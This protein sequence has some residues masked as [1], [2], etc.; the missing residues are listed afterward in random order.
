MVSPGQQSDGTRPSE[1]KSG[2]IGFH[3]S[4]SALIKTAA[5]CLLAI[6][7]L[8]VGVLPV[9]AAEGCCAREAGPSVYAP[10]PCCDESTVTPREAV[11]ILPAMSAGLV[12]AAPVAAIVVPD[13]VPARVPVAQASASS[14]HYE[15]DPPIFLLNAQFLI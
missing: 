7:V 13:A 5:V 3:M 6:L 1:L 2:V 10:M 14:A 4:V 15:P 9:C 12:A 8:A 11:R